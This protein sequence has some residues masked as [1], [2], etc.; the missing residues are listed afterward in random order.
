MARP[1]T[2]PKPTHL[3]ILEGVKPSRINKN[4]P[5]PRPIRPPMPR[6]LSQ[7]AKRIWQ[8]LAPE[9]E[10]AGLLTVVDGDAFAG[11]CSSLGIA[12]RLEKAAAGGDWREVEAWRKAWLQARQ[13]MTEFGMTPSS[14][15]RITVEKP[16]DDKQR[17]RMLD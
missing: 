8:R 17:E 3:K 2:K 4:D 7:D 13:Y 6:W 5:R 11:L 10:L 9:L 15:S 16:I 1:G 12:K 14:R